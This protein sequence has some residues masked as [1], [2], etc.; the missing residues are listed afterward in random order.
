LRYHDSFGACLGRVLIWIG[1]C[2]GFLLSSACSHDPEIDLATMVPG[3]S[4]RSDEIATYPFRFRSIFYHFAKSDIS[5]RNFLRLALVPDSEL[6]RAPQTSFDAIHDMLSSLNPR[7]II[8][9]VSSFPHP[10]WQ[11]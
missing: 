4:V 7:P 11:D 6:Y 1:L 5:Y 3:E 8:V 10:R 9:V 2:L